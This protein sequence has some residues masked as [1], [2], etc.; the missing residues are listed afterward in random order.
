MLR[1]T[2]CCETQTQHALTHRTCPHPRRCT[3]TFRG[4]T[5]RRRPCQYCVRVPFLSLNLAHACIAFSCCLC[6]PLAT[7]RWVRCVCACVSVSAV[8]SPHH[9]PARGTPAPCVVYSVLCL[10][11]CLSV[12]HA[13]GVPMCS[14]YFLTATPRTTP[15]TRPLCSSLPGGSA[16]PAD[17][18][19]RDAVSSTAQFRG[20][21][22]RAT[23]RVG[24]FGCVAKNNNIFSG[25]RLEFRGAAP[26][27]LAGLS[28]IARYC[29]RT[30]HRPLL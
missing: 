13:R 27:C 8:P 21:Q 17:G 28:L 2:G 23:H 4:R 30:T 16:A 6:P 22:R 25:F 14:L 26:Y 29:H 5:R 15:H 1:H 9:V 20:G 19:R 18:S 10:P 12:I 11:A 24:R 7:P 3:S